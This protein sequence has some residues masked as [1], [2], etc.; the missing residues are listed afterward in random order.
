MGEE[1][2]GFFFASQAHDKSGHGAAP[3]IV[4]D[5]SVGI[6]DTVGEGAFSYVGFVEGHATSDSGFDFGIADSAL[7]SHLHSNEGAQAGIVDVGVSGEAAVAFDGGEAVS[8]NAGGVLP[9]GHGESICFESGEDR[10]VAG[11]EMILGKG[12][13]LISPIPTDVTEI[14]VSFQQ[15]GEDRWVRSFRPWLFGKFHFHGV[16]VFFFTGC[17]E[18]NVADGHLIIDEG[19]RLQHLIGDASDDG[20]GFLTIPWS[21]LAVG[22]QGLE[23][24]R[25]FSSAFEREG[26]SAFGGFGLVD[27]L[28]EFL[29][30]VFR[31]R[32]SGSTDDGVAFF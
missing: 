11:S 5:A 25:D 28:G 31:K 3:V 4:E 17:E 23:L 26:K 7:E 20:I 15:C 10:L 21:G 18:P 9:A 32:F 13:H 6:V 19:F 27:R 2:S 22:A 30:D 14:F 16:E 24:Q 8:P 12:D 29:P 1:L